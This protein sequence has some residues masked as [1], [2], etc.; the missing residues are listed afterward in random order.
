M[1][2]GPAPAAAPASLAAG[3][4]A[5]PRT[6]PV[7]AAAAVVLGG[8]RG[9]YAA[10]PRRGDAWAG[11]VL[12]LTAT[13]AVAAAVLVRSHCRATLWA[14][15][16]QLV[17]ACYSDVASRVASG[18]V[19]AQPPGAALVTDA[20]AAATSLVGSSAGAGEDAV[21]VTFDLAA[22]LS[23][24]ALALAA[25]AL[26]ALTREGGRP[27]AA[28]AMVLSPLVVVSGLVSL[29]L[30]AVAGVAAGLLAHARGAP[31]LQGALLAAAAAVDPLAAV[32]LLALWIATLAPRAARVDGGVRA[33][34]ASAAAALATVVGIGAAWGLSGLAADAGRS[35]GT[36]DA[37][38]D[39]GTWVVAGVPVLDAVRAWAPDWGPVA[40]YGSPWVLPAVPGGP[41]ALPGLVV[42]CGAVAGTVAAAVVVGVLARRW[43]PV[44]RLPAS[45]LPRSDR[46]G[47]ARLASR[48]L[49]PPRLAPPRLAL[50][51]V[52]LVMMTAPAL[53]LQ[54]SLLLLPLVVA[55]G[56]PWRVTLPWA[57][58]ECVAGVTTWLYLYGQEVPARGADPWTYVV[59]VVVRLAAVAVL[60]AW[61][62]RAGPGDPVPAAAPGRL[63]G[64]RATARTTP[65]HH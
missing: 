47:S 28:S 34:A 11:P 51:A 17:H 26:V 58:V 43:A 21:V 27:W 37:A 62:L 9:R 10:P 19:A 64:G 54:S 5:A 18:T 31:A 55:A 38:P 53:P 40:G 6:D 16:D 24:L 60:A 61:A 14:S 35:A 57:L 56:L 52:A 36:A 4:A 3:T 7:V 2:A 46:R 45:D 12:A 22:V 50:V 44:S 63:G 49:T 23:A 41:G 39:G 30:L 65:A 15:P 29:E 33:V 59:V 42:V 32:V 25:L 48:H 20:L 8:A 13:L 1:P